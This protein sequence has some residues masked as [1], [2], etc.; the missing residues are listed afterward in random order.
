M[1]SKRV[2]LPAPVSPVTEVQATPAQLLQRESGLGGIGPKAERVSF[3]GSC[4][5]LSFPDGFNELLAERGLL[6]AQGWL[7]CN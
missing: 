2:V 4:V 3:K 1:A 6:L 5:V 7:F